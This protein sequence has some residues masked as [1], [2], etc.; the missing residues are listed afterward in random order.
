MHPKTP[1]ILLEDLLAGQRLAG[2]DWQPAAM[3]ARVAVAERDARALRAAL[4]ADAGLGV[5]GA[6]IQGMTAPSW[7]LRAVSALARGL[8]T[9]AG[10]TAAWRLEAEADM[11]GEAPLGPRAARLA[12]AM[13]LAGD[14][15]RA[16]AQAAQAD[17]V[18]AAVASPRGQ[19]Y[20]GAFDAFHAEAPARGTVVPFPAARTQVRCSTHAEER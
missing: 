15:R 1:T 4:D 10:D 11:R 8:G 7:P 13:A 9:P 6:A 3:C 17:R 18:A 19:A 16:V 20:D 2:G 12:Q 5:L 14:G